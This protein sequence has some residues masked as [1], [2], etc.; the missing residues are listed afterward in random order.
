MAGAGTLLLLKNKFFPP[1]RNVFPHPTP[2]SSCRPCWEMLWVSVQGESLVFQ[3]S[4][5]CL[6][7]NPAAIFIIYKSLVQKLRAK[8]EQNENN[9][10]LLEVLCMSTELTDSA[11]IGLK[12]NFS[13]LKWL[14]ERFHRNLFSSGMD[15][16]I[17]KAILSA[18]K[19]MKIIWV[20]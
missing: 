5:A 15:G 2:L 11:D 16:Q 1:K 17:P 9:L 8:S 12:E 6:Q 10:N 4:R 14:F 13:C 3:P 19:E 7:L 18:G 20:K